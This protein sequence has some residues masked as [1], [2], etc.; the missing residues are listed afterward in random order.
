MTRHFLLPS[1]IAL[2][3]IVLS[4]SVA[5]EPQSPALQRFLAGEFR[6]TVGAPLVSPAERPDDFCYSVKDPSI[7]RFE[8][9][10]HLYCTIR[11]QKRSHQI[12][13]FNFDDWP[14]AAAAERH[15]LKLTDGYFCAPQ[16]FFFTPQKR[17]YL[18]CQVSDPSRKPS[19]QPAFSTTET[20]TNP[21]SWSAPKLLFATHPQNV[22]AWIDFWVICDD[23]KAHL[24]FTSNNGLMWRAETRLAD[25]PG[26]WS[27]PVVVL[28]GDIFE[29]SHTYRLKGLDRFLT[30]IEAEAPG[31]RRY[32]KAYLA[33]S[34]DGEWEPLA[35]TIDKPF[36]GAANVTSRGAQWTES[37][38]HG[39]L[40]RSGHD[41]KM[42]VDPEHLQFL[43]QGVSDARRAGKKYGEIPWQLGMLEPSP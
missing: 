35:A 20:L 29:A 17:W 32:Y 31:G 12:E 25:F 40:V 1:F 34:L 21:S 13:Y 15:I 33:D 30:A 28:R 9:R 41:E 38:S 10:W 26:G 8:G 11:S 4:A 36:A 3:I 23:A 2:S 19:L 16:V 37:I 18:I 14:R 5:A 6:W 27:E 42:E 24:F 22:T 43:F 39:E 7:I